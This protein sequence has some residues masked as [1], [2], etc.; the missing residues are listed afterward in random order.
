MINLNSLLS[1][2]RYNSWEALEYKQ[3]ED[4][5]IRM[6]EHSIRM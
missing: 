3:H 6:C 4:R 5:G 1:R 2:L